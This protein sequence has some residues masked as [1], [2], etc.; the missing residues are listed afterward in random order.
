MSTDELCRRLYGDVGPESQWTLIERRSEGIVHGKDRA[1]LSGCGADGVQSSPRQQRV[2]R[3]L[4]P[5]QVGPAARFD[6]ACGVGQGEAMYL[7]VT[8]YFCIG[9]E[10]A[11]TVFW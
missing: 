5:N 7:P 3:R 11:Q 8:G 6:P 10:P 1:T 9:S 4:Q 2:R